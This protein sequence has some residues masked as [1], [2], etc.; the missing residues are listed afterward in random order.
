MNPKVCIIGLGYIG[1]PTAVLAATKFEVYGYDIN[2]DIIKII[3]SGKAHFYEP[4]LD[5]LL[6][7]NISEGRFVSGNAIEACDIYII[8]V[9]TP[10]ISSGLQKKPDLSYVNEAIENISKVLKKGDLI[11]LE[12][13]SPVGTTEGIRDKLSSLRTDLKLQKEKPDISI[14]YCPERVLPGKMLDELISNDRIIGGLGLECA[15]RAKAFYKKFVEGDCI[16]TTSRMAEMVKLT[17][18]SC[19]DSQIAFANELSILA[20]KMDIDIWELIY[21]ANKH[22]RI[23]ILNPGPG[24]GGHCIAVD[25][26]FLISEYPESTRFMYQARQINKYK[27]EWVVKKIQEK[28]KELI[29]IKDCLTEENITIAL[30]GLTYK[31]NVNDIRESP[32]LNI[33]EKIA[34]LHKG[35]VLGIDPNLQALRTNTKLQFL[36]IEAAKQKADI[37]VILVN[38]KQFNNIE[39]NKNSLIDTTGSNSF[40]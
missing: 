40:R 35:K 27:E 19:R 34:S 24:V 5:E 7:K 15:K 28:V 26:W 13:T 29:S 3:N 11:I 21:L 14:A 39:L 8:C 23:N 30:Y 36:S 6:K 38:H 31:P 33:A 16:E 37:E 32:A 25:P 22:P 9:P 4:N 18:N 10:F 17:E 20:D 1:L 12:S 2:P